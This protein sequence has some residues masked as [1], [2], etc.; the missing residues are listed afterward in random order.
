VRVHEIAGGNPFFAL[1]LG[2]A[3]ARDAIRVDSANV[4]LPESLSALVTERLRALPA[5]VRETLAAVAALA[6]PSLTVLE[7]LAAGVIDDIELAEN[8]GVVEFDGERIHFTHPLLAP[9]SYAAMPPH[10]RRRLHRRLAELDVDLEERARHLA[11]AST[12]PDEGIAAAL[13]AA[14]AHAHGRGAAL[15]AAELA[16]RAVTLTPVHAVESVNNRR[17]TAAQHFL[18]AGDAKRARGSSRRRDWLFRPRPNQSRSFEPARGH[19]AVNGGLSRGSESVP[20]CA[21]RAWSRQPP[22]SPHS[23]RACVDGRRRMGSQSRR[24]VRRGCPESR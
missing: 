11:I 5:R 1:E 20:P 14:A 6:A 21:C 23:L 24:K 10:G 19:G 13:D 12:G 17:I 8:Q 18:S 16:E 4:T 2:R 22:K 15:V 9:A 3:I 7:P